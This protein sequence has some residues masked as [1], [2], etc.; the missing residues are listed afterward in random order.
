MRHYKALMRKN[1]I[2]W[3]RSWIS[4]CCEL[5]CPVAL[6][7]ILTL[8]RLAVSITPTPSISLIN[9]TTIFYPPVSTPN[10]SD[11]AIILNR[12]NVAY[13]KFYAFSDI[14]AWNNTP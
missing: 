2:L 13:K 9:N 11:F 8:A 4:S 5:L 6:M 1:W 14:A 7:A 3:K 12:T 10:N